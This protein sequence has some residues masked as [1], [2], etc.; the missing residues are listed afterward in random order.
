VGKVKE[1]KKTILVILLALILYFPLIFLGLGFHCDSYNLM[2]TVKSL[3]QKHIYMPSRYPGNPVH[4]LLTTLLYVLGGSLLTNLGSLLMSLVVIYFFIKICEY[5]NIAHKHLLA[6]FMITQPLYYAASTFTI[7]YLYALGFLLIGYVSLIK[8]RYISAGIFWGFAI[9]TRMSSALFVIALLFTYFRNQEKDKNSCFL[10]AS[11]S[12]IIGGAFFILPFLYAGRTF[13]FLTYYMGHWNWIG[14]LS[15]FVYKNLYFWGLQTSLVFLCVLTL[16]IN[17]FKKNYCSVYKKIVTAAVLMIIFYEAYFLGMPGTKYYLL[18]MLPFVLILLG[19]ALKQRRSVLILLMVV[20]ISY[21]FLSINIARPNVPNNATA[22]IAGLWVERGY[23][24]ND[25]I[26]RMKIKQ[27]TY[28][29][30]VR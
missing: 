28:Q 4:E 20:Q 15:R 6:I 17:G 27:P 29:E 1:R 9:G 18:P 24:V 8:R 22:I 11:I 16:I 26:E 30:L 19:I 21:N 2:N 10:S 7:D 3:T 5:H 23:L 14:Y 13:A 25:T 12:A